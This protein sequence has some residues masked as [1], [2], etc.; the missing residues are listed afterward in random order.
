[1]F[2]KEQQ[3]DLLEAVLSHAT[4]SQIHSFLVITSMS[5]SYLEHMLLYHSQLLAYYFMFDNVVL[6]LVKI[7]LHN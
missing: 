6:K 3:R 5:A 1:M 7:S 2:S 4:H